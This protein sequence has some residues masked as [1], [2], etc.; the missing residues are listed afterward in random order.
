[1]ENQPSGTTI[2]TFSSTDQDVP[3]NTFTYTLVSGTGS[4]DNGSFTI[5]G[6]TL[7]SAASFDFETKSSYSIRVQTDDGHGGTFQKQFTITVNDVNDAPVANADSYSGV[8]GNTKAQLGTSSSGPV[9]TLT[10]NKLIANDTDQDTTFPHTVSAVAETVSSTGGGSATINTDGSF[11]YTPPVGAENTTDTF[12][13]HAT[14]GS[15]TSAGTVTMHIANVRVWYLDNSLG[16]N[17]SGTSGSPFNTLG[18]VNGAGGSGD[19]DGTGDYL[20]LYGSANYTGGLPLEASQKLVGQANGLTVD[21]GFGNQ[22]LVAATGGTA[23]NNPTIQNAGGDAIQLANGSDVE[24][25]NAGTASGVGVKGTSVTTS[26]VGG[27]TTISGAAGGAFALSGAAGGNISVGSTITN[28]ANKSVSIASRSSGTVSLT[29]NVTDT[30]TGISLSNNSG[31]AVDFSG[32]LTLSTGANSALSASGPGPGATTGGTVTATNTGSTLT[33]TTGTA[34]NVLNTTIGAAGLTFHDISSNGA[35]N[36]IRLNNTGS[37]DGLT[38]TG[39]GGSTANGSGGTIQNSTADGVRLT[40]AGGTTSLARMNITGSDDNGLYADGSP[41]T[42]DKLNV[43]GSGNAAPSSGNPESGLAYVNSIGTSSIS[44]TSVTTSYNNNL[45]WEPTSGSGTLNVSSSNFNSSGQGPSTG[46]S[47][48]SL[49]AGG[50]STPTLA[51]SGGQIKNNPSAD[52]LAHGNSS[53]QP[54]VSASGVDMANAAATPTNF[55]VDFDTASTAHGYY[56]L[57]GSTIKYAGS[58]AASAVNINPIQ[59]SSIDVTITGNTIGT[60]GTAAGDANSGTVNN[61]GI[62]AEVDDDSHAKINVS[63]NTIS[64]TDQD[65]I[66]LQAVDFSATATPHGTMDATIRNNTVNTPDDN[67]AFPFGTIP[68]IHVESRK[69]DIVCLDIHANDSAHVGSAPVG[70]DFRTRQ[71]DTSTFN[72]ERLTGNAADDTN[73]ENFLSSE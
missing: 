41:T 21:N 2:G 68:G 31:A 16:S 33:T 25:V 17:G 18:S 39:D 40:S 67:S 22:A 19:S 36:G 35:S 27:T 52:L 5:S 48:V 10:G 60:P 50:S 64:H 44:N 37:S 65:G 46:N 49:V 59:T 15:A 13:Y 54:H 69:D 24:R 63:N 14:D 29:G 73:I 30:G 70:V 38:V 9:V 7:K 12:T 62:A 4:T 3:A 26:T 28:S 58:S 47:G 55:G 53:S 32:Q 57:T 66:F 71:R 34:L 6:S 61:F 72:L 51:I 23:A 8:V 45:D 56:S 43:S 42:L 20:F 1:D 11:T